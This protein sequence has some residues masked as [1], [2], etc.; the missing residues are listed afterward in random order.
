MILSSTDKPRLLFI[1]QAV[2]ERGPVLGFVVGWLRAFSRAFSVRALCLR[3]GAHNLDLVGVPV[4][5]LGKERGGNRFLYALRFIRYIVRN[6]REY[7]AVFVHM[8]PEYVILGAIFW[9][10]TGKR[11]ALWY[12]HTKGGFRLRLAIMLSD[13]VFHTSPYSASARSEKAVRMPAGI[14]T[15]LFTPNATVRSARTI[16]F[17]G[18]I[19]PVKGV[20]ILVEAARLLHSQGED[21]RLV[22]VGDARLEDKAYYERL[23]NTLRP[24]IEA[25]KAELHSAVSNHDAVRFFQ[26]A[27]V[28]VNLTPAGNYDK[29]V[30]EAAASGALPLVS[31]KAF[32]DCFPPACFFREDDSADLA[33][34]LKT[35]FAIPRRNRDVVAAEARSYVVET[36]DIAILVKSIAQSLS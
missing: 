21:F 9:R 25:G 22:V 20:H 12:N 16:L 7:D 14:D 18:R 13:K 30:L 33:E 36:H 10:L 23:K 3:K 4:D 35:F 26:S 29:T 2:D 24:V 34:K 6:R 1:T 32:I 31:S 15:A 28:F 19:A 17:L 11:V 27:D 5:S 8:N